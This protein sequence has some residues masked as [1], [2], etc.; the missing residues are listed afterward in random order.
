MKP[1]RGQSE[2][3]GNLPNRAIRPYS[4]FTESLYILASQGGEGG[5]CAADASR[6]E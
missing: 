3:C 1:P 5:S 2:I 6:H 4:Y